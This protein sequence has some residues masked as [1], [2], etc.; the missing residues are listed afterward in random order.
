M[1]GVSYVSPTYYADRLCERGRLYLRKFF[2]GDD[3][4]LWND[5]RDEKTR[6]EAGFRIERKEKFG[7][8]DHK[9]TDAE[10]VMEKK[11]GDQVAYDMKDWMLEKVE[12]EF[13]PFREHPD[14]LLKWS[15]PY[16]KRLGS[17]MFW[18]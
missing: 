18:M 11:H 17:T 4:A 2:N 9:K 5:F 6:R 10:K 14:P 3:A 7:G 8:H 1:C 12:K 13:Y 16:S 15:N